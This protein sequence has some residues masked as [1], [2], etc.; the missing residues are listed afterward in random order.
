MTRR[1]STLL[2][3]TVWSVLLLV[4]TFWLHT[5]NNDFPYYYHTDEPGKVEQMLSK[6]PLNFHHP[7]LMLD[8]ARTF[9]RPGQTMQQGVEIGRDLSAAFT[10]VAVVALSLMAYLWRGEIMMFAVGLALATHHQ[11]FELS[12]YFKEDTA[13][14][15]GVGL[16]FLALHFFDRFPGLRTAA[17][18]G[19][20]IGLAISGKVA[21]AL[22]LV[23]AIAVIVSRRAIAS[24]DPEVLPSRHALRRRGGVALVVA[25]VIPMAVTV[26]LINLQLVESW[27]AAS[28]SLSR[29]QNLVVSGQGMAQKVP[30]SKYWNVFL[31]NT[32]PVMW[33]LILAALWGAWARRRQMRTVEWATILFPFLVAIVL[34]FLPKDND[35]YFLPATALFTVLAAFGAGE[36]RHVLP[37]ALRQREFATEAVA[38][39]LIVLAQFPG[40]T[41]DRGGLLRYWTAFQQDDNAELVAWL[42]QN[43]PPNTVIAKDEKVRLPQGLPFKVLSEDYVAD[44]APKG[45]SGVDDFTK[46]ASYVIVTDNTFGRFDRPDYTPK[47]KDKEIED[48]LRRKTF[49]ASLRGENTPIRDWRR[50]TVIYLHP[51]LEIYHLTPP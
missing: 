46:V 11:L 44:L 36:I 30:H 32:T 13:M 7:L 21:G 4:L 20:A 2:R 35:R 15:F 51:G 27:G 34:S 25:M 48:Y 49:Y 18:V 31:A 24:Q 12:H 19:L 9:A 5:R 38:A 29:E 3:L 8:A 6:R 40:W 23:P 37:P 45:S 33:V 28:A 43:L 41:E 14:L 10:S 50:G 1:V 22:V 26:L 47:G 17:A 16:T 42:Q 39:L